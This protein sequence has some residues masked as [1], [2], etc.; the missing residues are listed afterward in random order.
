MQTPNMEFIKQKVLKMNTS[1]AK[2]M[3]M[4]KPFC[5]FPYTISLLQWKVFPILKYWMITKD[6]CYP[7]NGKSLLVIIFQGKK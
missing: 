7:K 2:H 4:T 5:L 1:P 6:N 3:K